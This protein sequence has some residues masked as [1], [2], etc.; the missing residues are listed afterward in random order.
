MIKKF[1][2]QCGLVILLVVSK[3]LVMKAELTVAS[4][5]GRDFTSKIATVYLTIF[6]FFVFCSL[7]YINR[8]T[9][10]KKKTFLFKHDW[11]YSKENSY[12]WYHILLK[13]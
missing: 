12:G 9:A 6:F 2:W 5:N 3:F 1:I 10:N 8:F 13:V 4:Y 11:E 7:L